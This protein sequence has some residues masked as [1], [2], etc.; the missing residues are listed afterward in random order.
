[1]TCTCVLIAEV[2]YSNFRLDDQLLTDV[3][4]WDSFDNYLY[5]RCS[6]LLLLLIVFGL[7]VY[8]LCLQTI[9]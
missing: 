4:S 6:M 5:L 9:G 7:V 1:M 2:L 3:E 8:C